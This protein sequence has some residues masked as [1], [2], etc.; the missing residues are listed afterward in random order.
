M[1]QPRTTPN[2]IVLAPLI[3]IAVVLV[4]GLVGALMSC[5]G[6]GDGCRDIIQASKIESL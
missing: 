1:R 4:I 2:I 6:G 3:A 5:P